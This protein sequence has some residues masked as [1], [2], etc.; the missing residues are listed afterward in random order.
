MKKRDV[1]LQSFPVSGEK[2]VQ[3]WKA[4]NFFEMIRQEEQVSV[5]NG[6]KICP[7]RTVSELSLFL[8]VLGIPAGGGLHFLLHNILGVV[9][10]FIIIPAIVCIVALFK[11]GLPKLLLAAVPWVNCNANK[12]AERS[13]IALH[14]DAFRILLLILDVVF[15]HYM[16]VIGWTA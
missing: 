1:S 9:N 3:R 7:T 10:Y 2:T 4:L 12:R 6:E 14:A 13:W 11:Y 15:L 5:R 16:K 8:F